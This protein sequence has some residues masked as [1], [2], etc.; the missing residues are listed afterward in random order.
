MFNNLKNFASLMSQAGEFRQK[1]AQ[2]QAEIAKKTVEADAGAGAVRVVMN[3]KLEVVSVKLDRPLLATL[4]G[5][6][7]DADQQMVEDLIASAV[8]AAI[9]KTQEMVRQEMMNLTGGMNLPGLDMLMGG[10]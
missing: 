6:G 1:L 7:P 4:A 8:N 5:Q 10:Q 3:G 2:L 9:V